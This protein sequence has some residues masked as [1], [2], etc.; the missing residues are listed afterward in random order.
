MIIEDR[1]VQTK[2]YIINGNNYLKLRN[3]S[4]LL[5]NTDIAFDIKLDSKTGETQLILGGEYEEQEIEDYSNNNPIKTATPNNITLT[6]N[7][8]KYIIPSYII[9]DN[10]YI[11]FRDVMPLIGGKIKWEDET[12]TVHLC[13]IGP[14]NQLKTVDLEQNKSD[15]KLYATDYTLWIGQNPEKGVYKMKDWKLTLK[16]NYNQK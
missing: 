6:I 16:R 7:D 14:T 2:T 4:N 3:M 5:K 9:Y 8:K 10:N 1:L 13:G 15:N 11:K 12:S